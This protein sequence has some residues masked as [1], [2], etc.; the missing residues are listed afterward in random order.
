MSIPIAISIAIRRHADP[1]VQGTADP[2]SDVTIDRGAAGPSPGR[3]RVIWFRVFF[4]RGP[5]GSAREQR[6]DKQEGYPEP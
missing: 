5:C 2:R 4:L 1:S 3:T 6:V